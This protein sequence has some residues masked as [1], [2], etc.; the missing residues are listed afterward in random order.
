MP[1]S[2]PLTVVL[3]LA[4]ALAVCARVS[5]HAQGAGE[6]VTE[7]EAVGSRSVAPLELG[8]AAER[9]ERLDEAEGHYVA[10]LEAARAAGDTRT[11]RLALC[12]LGGLLSAQGRVRDAAA[13]LQQAVPL[14]DEAVDRSAPTAVRLMLTDTYLAHGAPVDALP[15]ADAAV[16]AAVASS[17]S[18]AADDAVLAAACATYVRTTRLIGD[19]PRTL[20]ST[21]AHLQE[22]LQAHASPPTVAAELLFVHGV[23]LL[24]AVDR[25]RALITLEDALALADAEDADLDRGGLLTAIGYTALELGDARRAREAFDAGLGHGGPARVALLSGLAL[26]DWQEGWHERAFDRLGQAERLTRAERAPVDRAEVLTTRATFHEQRGDLD[27]A[28]RD[29]D[30]ATDLLADHGS[31]EAEARARGRLA[32][33][34]ARQRRWAEAELEALRSLARNRSRHDEA[35]QAPRY[36]SVDAGVDALVA[37]AQVHRADEEPDEAQATMRQALG[38]LVQQGRHGDASLVAAARGFLDLELGEPRRAL[39]SFDA[40]CAAEGAGE[41]PAGWV[42]S[43]GAAMAH[44]RLGDLAAAEQALSRAAAAVEEGAVVPAEDRTLPW[45]PGERAPFMA[46]VELLLEQQR[47]E[48]A[49]AVT[50]RARA[51]T[52]ETTGVDDVESFR[53]DMGD[54]DAVLVTLLGADQTVAWIVTADWLTPVRWPVGRVAIEQAV[55]DLLAALRQPPQ[56]GRRAGEA[57]REPAAHLYDLALRPVSEELRHAGR[58]WWLPDGALAHAPAAALVG[59]DGVVV[60][61]RAWSVRVGTGGTG[62]PPSLGRRTAA[63]A[64]GDPASPQP[65]AETGEF[66]ALQ[67]TCRKADVLDLEL[68]TEAAALQR[69]GEVVVA[70]VATPVE[71]NPVRVEAGGLLLEEGGGHDGRL[72]VGEIREMPSAPALVVLTGCGAEPL[73]GLGADAAVERSPASALALAE[74][75]V[76]AGA[77][78]VLVSLW[79]VDDASLQAVLMEFYAAMARVDAAT[80]LQQVQA[81]MAAD[82]VHP[83]HWAGW[84]VVQ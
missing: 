76:E 6:A 64:I 78:S 20:R 48:E 44:W 13:A 67:Q 77:G 59:D 81:A 83:H 80:A 7:G 34:N 4:L 53:A 66:A 22:L 74:A 17:S 31:A 36:L 18:E 69:L 50:C 38:L 29:L 73:V 8:R 1:E 58:I 70:H 26:L 19:D 30:D 62:D 5:A 41:L 2:R 24:Q 72:C 79:A 57:W 63:V 65:L 55:L 42:A 61:S 27:L 35:G 60:T 49:F 33:V 43:H 37:L 21:A 45:L 12:H 68:A 32:R 3:A 15:W 14:A 9:E 10:A 39:E 11:E 84:F 71:Y 25:E 56:H 46:L 82:E 16:R 51:A 40:L 52:G 47:Y 23:A 28:R 75:F 54:G